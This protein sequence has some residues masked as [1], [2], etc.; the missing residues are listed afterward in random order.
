MWLYLLLLVF[1][2]GARLIPHVPNFS[3]LAAFALF[4]AAYAPHKKGGI[5]LPLGMYVI[6]D[7]MLGLHGAV[8][9]TW[10]SAALIYLIGTRLRGRISTGRI[11]GYTL[12]SSLL[13]YL[14]TNFGV[15]MIGWYPHTVNGLLT[16]YVRALPF[17]RISLT[18]NLIYAGVAFGAYEWTRARKS[19]PVPHCS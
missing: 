4:A 15:W 5:L 18:A 11:A 16:C 14:V 9:F 8:L 12:G 6:S 2:I 7:M 19:M 1:G 13:F 3:P 17:L 10:G